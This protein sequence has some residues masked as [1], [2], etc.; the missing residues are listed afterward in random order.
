[1]AVNDKGAPGKVSGRD[2]SGLTPAQRA[3]AA[4]IQRAEAEGLTFRAYCGREGLSVSG[5]Y[6][7]RKVLRDARPKPAASP[8]RSAAVRLAQGERAGTAHVLLPNG[9][10][11]AVPVDDI[12][13]AVRLAAGLSQLGR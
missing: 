2:E 5:L 10:Q 12:D 9:V 4:H 6:S 13:D 11:L 8:P 3:W 7:A 1:M